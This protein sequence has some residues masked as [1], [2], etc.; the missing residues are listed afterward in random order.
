MLNLM[1]WME[2]EL[3]TFCSETVSVFMCV[4]VYVKG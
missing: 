1:E 4:Y 3:I 2:K